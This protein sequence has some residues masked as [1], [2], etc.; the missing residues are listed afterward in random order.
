MLPDA[1]EPLIE[2]AR[3]GDESACAALYHHLVGYVYRLAYGLLLDR[4]D[5]E[6]VVQDSFAYAFQNLH[7]YDSSRSAFRT[8]LYTITVS[9]CRNKRR[10]KWLPTQSITQELDT[11]ISRDSR[12]EHA[13]TV[14]LSRRVIEEALYHLS[15][16]LREAVVLRYFDGLSYREMSEILGCPPKT[17]ES[18]VRL[19]QEALFKL[20]AAER[21]TLLGGFA[22]DVSH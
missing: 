15:P 2:S 12:P 10:R 16:R 6:E 1:L 21:E 13:T 3:L 22:D 8:W 5:T 4:M 7:Q 20:L 19:A 11:L 17:A 9:R 14:H 18:R